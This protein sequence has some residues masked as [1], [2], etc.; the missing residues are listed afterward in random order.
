MDT[1]VYSDVVGEIDG[2]DVVGEIDG[3]DV[4]AKVPSI[5]KFGLLYA[6]DSKPSQLL[7]LL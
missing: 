7:L 5:L 3:A 4:G 1:D 6:V 2:Q